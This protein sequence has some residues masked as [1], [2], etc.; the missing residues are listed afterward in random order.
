MM[1]HSPEVT[2]LS[3]FVNLDTRS[4]AHV[5]HALQSKSVQGDA[6]ANIRL[7]FAEALQ[8][9]ATLAA[10][11]KSNTSSTSSSAD[12]AEGAARPP[13]TATAASG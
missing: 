3:D 10:S 5:L 11:F 12:N 9:V 1:L 7:L 2:A 4:Q 6:A 8:V 13:S